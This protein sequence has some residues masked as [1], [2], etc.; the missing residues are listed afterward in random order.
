MVLD[1]IAAWAIL[2]PLL[3]LGSYFWFRWQLQWP[4]GIVAYPMGDKARDRK[5]NQEA[6]ERDLAA[7]QRQIQFIR[8][9]WPI[10][11]TMLILGIGL[12]IYNIAT[13]G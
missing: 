3:W 2:L 6:M 5:A 1:V 7:G 13:G 12:T 9:L 8:R 4:T 10:F 11:A